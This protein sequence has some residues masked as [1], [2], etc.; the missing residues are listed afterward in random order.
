MDVGGGLG[1]QSMTLAQNF[2]HL[3][4]VIQDREPVLKDTAQVSCRRYSRPG[5]Y[6]H[7]CCSSGMDIFQRLAK[8]A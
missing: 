3:R 8:M 2:S 7:S 6:T 4:F 1:S 5:N